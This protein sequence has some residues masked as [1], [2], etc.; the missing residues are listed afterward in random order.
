MDIDFLTIKTAIFFDEDIVKEY[1]MTDAYSDKMLLSEP[2]CINDSNFLINHN[3]AIGP[4][5]SS[6]HIVSIGWIYKHL[7]FNRYRESMFDK[8]FNWIELFNQASCK[9]TCLLLGGSFLSEKECPKDID[10]LIVYRALQGFNASALHDILVNKVEIADIRVV[11]ED[12]SIPMLIKI[13]CFFHT[14]YQGTYSP[15]DKGSVLVIM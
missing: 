6:P 3:V 10:A 1:V 14:L 2:N 13:S 9:V 8:F 7:L 11:P 15:H 4:D 12:V 5:H